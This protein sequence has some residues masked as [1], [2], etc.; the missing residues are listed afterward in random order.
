MIVLIDHREALGGKSPLQ[1]IGLAPL[2]DGP[3]HDREH[4]GEGEVLGTGLTPM[5]CPVP[6]MP[7]FQMG[8]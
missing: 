5:I 4:G 6:L 2:T 8:Q 3:Y 7:A 1:N